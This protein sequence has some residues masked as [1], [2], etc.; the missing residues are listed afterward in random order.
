MGKIYHK[1]RSPTSDRDK[2]GAGNVLRP[3]R[4]HPTIV[5]VQDSDYLDTITVDSKEPQSST[6]HETEVD[7]ESHGKGNSTPASSQYAYGHEEISYAKGGSSA[8]GYAM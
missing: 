8:F 7:S 2:D 5:H 6:V 1:H 4:R 3:V